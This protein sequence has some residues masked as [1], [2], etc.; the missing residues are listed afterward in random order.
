MDADGYYNQLLEGIL[1]HSKD[2]RAVEKKNQWIVT[3][4]G[5]RSMR[6]TNVEWKLRMKWKDGTV[7][8]TSL[9][10]IK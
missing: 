6:Q 4:R 1:D 8:W 3:K 2:K 9:K 7:P 5:R 10:D